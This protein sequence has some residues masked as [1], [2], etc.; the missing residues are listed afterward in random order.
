MECSIYEDGVIAVTLLM[1]DEAMPQKS[2]FGLAIRYLPP[3][4]Y[5]DKS[6][7]PVE[8]TNS[9][10]GETDWF[11]LPYSFGVAIGKCLIQQKTAGL[12]GFSDDG[13]AKMVSWLVEMEE[14][15]DAMCY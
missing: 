4:S 14:I 11:I 5:Q 8:T 9:M 7:N 13:F 6:G 2:R 15:P 3:E 1:Q 10:G 12:P